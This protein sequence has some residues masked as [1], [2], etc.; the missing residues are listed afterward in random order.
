ME[1]VNRGIDLQLLVV[2]LSNFFANLASFSRSLFIKFTFFTGRSI[3]ITN[4][5]YLKWTIWIKTAR[6][7]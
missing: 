7:E 1:I 6:R 5:R 2:E 3:Q 4:G